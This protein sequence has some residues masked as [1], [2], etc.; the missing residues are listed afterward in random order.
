MHSHRED[1]TWV[2]RDGD[3]LST[4]GC[5]CLKDRG[6]WC[7]QDSRDLRSTIRPLWGRAD[8]LEEES[9]WGR[10]CQSRKPAREGLPVMNGR[11]HAQMQVRVLTHQKKAR[12]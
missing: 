7:L 1:G 12:G 10:G 8:G 6:R 11:S 5:C 9:N 2:D 4:R 3:L